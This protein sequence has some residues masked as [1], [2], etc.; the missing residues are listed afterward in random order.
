MRCFLLL[1][2]V[3]W[4][5]GLSVGTFTRSAVPDYD[6]SP[7]DCEHRRLI[8]VRH[9]AV[10]PES[11]D[12]PLRQGAVYGGSYNVPLSEAGVAEAAAI[13]SLISIAHGHEVRQLCA[14]PRAMHSGRLI[15]RAVSP[16]VVGG[17]PLIASPLLV[18]ID[19]GAW[20]GLTV[21]E[22]EALWGQEAFARCSREDDYGREVVGG[23][24]IGTVRSRSLAMRDA[25]LQRTRPGT[26]SVLC[27][28]KWVAR[29][30]LSEA[31]AQVED[32]G[33]QIPVPTA[34]ISIVDFP[35]GT[36]PLDLTTALEERG[37]FFPSER[38]VPLVRVI[39]YKP[40]TA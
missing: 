36:W 24:G 33:S 31:L 27:T 5:T 38:S 39:G 37:A 12:P 26:A 14:S 21:P 18:D 40:G 19:R 11:H 3:A 25:V 17:L 30:I 35:D 32:H 23:E 20:D 4:S 2:S 10:S 8:L 29:Q 22:I 16:L 13:A 6:V 7:C 15:A 34:S 1:Q 9:G 28:H